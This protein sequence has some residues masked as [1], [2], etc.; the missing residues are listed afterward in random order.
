MNF[1]HY[2][3]L[4][5]KPFKSKQPKLIFFHGFGGFISNSLCSKALYR[6][7]KGLCAFLFRDSP[8]ALHL[9]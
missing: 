1:L 5:K 8:I 4:F 3:Q 9:E 6:I 7:K 2:K